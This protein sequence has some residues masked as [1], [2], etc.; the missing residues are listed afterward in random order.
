[1]TCLCPKEYFMKKVTF[2]ILVAIM[3]HADDK[4]IMIDIKNRA[5]NN[6]APNV[7]SQCYT[8]T[9]DE[10]GKVHNPCFNC[11]IDSQEPNYI[12]DW[13]IQE[14][15]L[16]TEYALKNHWENLFKDRTKAVAKISDEE[17]NTYISKSNYHDKNHKLILADTLKNLPSAWD[18]DGDKKWDGYI[19][20]CYF[21][22]DDAGFDKNPQG[23]YTGWRAFGYY[24]FLGTFW[25]T[26]GSTD[27]VLI[28]L[29]MDFRVNKEGVFDIE[30]YKINL[31]IVEALIKQKDINTFE[32]DEKKYAV[33]L[34]KDG[35]LDTATKIRFE[36]DPRN[37]EHMHYVGQANEKAYKIAAG[38]YP[39][40]TD[41]LHTV[42]YIDSD[43]NGTIRMAPRMKEL[44]Y[45]KKVNWANYNDHQ[46]LIEEEL[47]ES[48]DFPDRLEVFIGDAERG[49]SNK[50][51]WRYQGFIEDAKGELRPQS[52]EENLLCIGCHASLGAIVD[53]TFAYQRKFEHD[54]FQDGWHH[55][56]QKG[57]KGVKEPKTPDGR[58]EY[59]LYLQENGA[60]DEFRDNAEVQAKFFDANATV[61]KE[62]LTGLHEDIS[63]LLFPSVKR[64]MML[65]KAYKVIVDEQ[66]F[67]YGRDAHVK[68]VKNVHESFNDEEETG[69]KTPVRYYHDK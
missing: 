31:L 57:L 32:I 10:K 19:P 33:D 52:Y 42:R 46:A 8:K 1:M 21:D 44:R 24:P 29:P 40:G 30:T 3:I 14:G 34:D 5:L 20:D 12:N 22:F 55:W 66:S 47:K 63:T 15:Y 18:I 43:E 62:M 28:R 2:S 41:F 64:A 67:I 56:S 49:V 4:S 11:H 50:R 48:H 37:G 13:D 9:E 7:P 61:K 35:K 59:S 39:K 36:Y 53:S 69:I 38:L 26:N 17:I 60:G 68:P 27:D 54:T 16:F 51:G 6:E 23:N 65:N 25:P 45:G 58:Y